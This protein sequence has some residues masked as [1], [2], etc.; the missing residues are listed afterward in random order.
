MAKKKPVKTQKDTTTKK[1]FLSHTGSKYEVLYVNG[2][3]VTCQCIESE[4]G[5]TPTFQ[6]FGIDKEQI[7]KQLSFKLWEETK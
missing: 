6:P 2:E 1:V 7:N 5:L 3:P 4:S